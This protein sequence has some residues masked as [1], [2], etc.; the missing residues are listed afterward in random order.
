MSETKTGTILQPW[1]LEDAEFVIAPED[2]EN[3]IWVM[4]S[5]GRQHG[6]IAKDA[7]QLSQSGG[8][9]PDRFRE[10]MMK[11]WFF[12]AYVEKPEMWVNPSK[13]STASDNH[14]TGSEDNGKASTQSKQIH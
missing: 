10:W 6:L 13:F 11:V 9:G 1:M 14:K 12:K 2:S 4:S 8:K 5:D 7:I 3:D